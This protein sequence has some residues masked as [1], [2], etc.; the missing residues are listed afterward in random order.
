MT[1]DQYDTPPS[2]C[3]RFTVAMSNYSAQ[4]TMDSDI[5]NGLVKS[6]R[7]TPGSFYVSLRWRVILVA[8]EY[9]KL[10]ASGERRASVS[11]IY[12]FK[13]PSEEPEEKEA[14]HG[15]RTVYLTC[16]LILCHI[17]RYIRDIN[18]MSSLIKLLIQRGSSNPPPR[19]I[20]KSSCCCT[21]SLWIECILMC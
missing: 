10:A 3:H 6:Y 9:F 1:S 5:S 2:S 14:D 13:L 21:N 17:L 12:S 7:A 16:H 15:K 11:R 19:R 4:I 20:I 18:A 8:V